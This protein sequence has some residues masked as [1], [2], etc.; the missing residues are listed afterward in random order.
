[1]GK[2]NIRVNSISPAWT[3]SPEV[4]KIDPKG[5]MFV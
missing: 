2:D 1:M 3:W 5:N 4:A